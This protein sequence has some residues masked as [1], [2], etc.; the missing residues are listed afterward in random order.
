MNNSLKL[1]SLFLR[2]GLATVFIWFGV[3]KFLHPQYWIDAW[4]PQMVINIL[5]S[6]QLSTEVFVYLNGI[7]EVVIGSSLLA[8]LYTKFSSVLALGFLVTIIIFN[9][10]NEI[11]VRDIG[12]MGGLLSLAFWPERRN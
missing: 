12:L 5:D 3:D 2:L 9:G 10:F 8:N 6:I 1:P 7:F 4:L 11:T